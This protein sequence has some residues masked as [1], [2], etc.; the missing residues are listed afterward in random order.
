MLRFAR[1][2]VVRSNFALSLDLERAGYQTMTMTE[3]HHDA[4]IC[5]ILAAFAGGRDTVSTGSTWA[6][7]CKASECAWWDDSHH[8]CVVMILPLEMAGKLASAKSA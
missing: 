6:I 2:D 4:K 3:G 1:N 8:A 7:R 5:P